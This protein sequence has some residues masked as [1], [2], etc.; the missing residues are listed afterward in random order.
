V[1]TLTAQIRPIAPSD[2]DRLRRFHARLSSETI[3]G[4]YHGVHPRLA[5]SEVAFLVAA[6]GRRHVAFVACDDDGELLGVCRL[7]GDGEEPD[8]GEIAVVVADS[9]QHHGLGHELVSR[10]LAQA[11]R[12][13]FRHVRALILATNHAARHLFVC[14]AEEDGVPFSTDI[15]GGVVDL[16]LELGRG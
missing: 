11:S 7:I 3:Y 6:D 16:R 14:V 15:S 12:A 5:D 4:R 13:G 1:S 10:V 8:S 2:A 9:A